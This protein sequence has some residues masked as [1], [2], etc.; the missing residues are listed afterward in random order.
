MKALLIPVEFIK[1]INEAKPYVRIYWL[2]WLSDY[3]DEIFRPD[4]PEYFQSEM[5]GKNVEL[6]LET[7]KEA[8]I[9]GI[10]YFKD[11]FTFSQIKKKDKDISEQEAALVSKVINHLN[12]KCLTT[13][14]PSK[15]NRE[16]ILARAKEGYTISDF[17]RVIDK[18]SSQWM[19]TD[20][21]KYL[22]PIT[23]FQAKKF[24]NYLNEPENLIN[25]GKP[26]TKGTI[27]QLS[28]A[29]NKAK[30]LFT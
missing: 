15:P 16:C 1:A 4:Y 30:Q 17:I 21:Q 27:G 26:K 12:L 2:K 22:R 23:L 9:I 13:Y 5:K 6:S 7:I 10:P 25:D 28:S 11:G 8:Y 14:T 3:T 29:A 19:N 20:Q 24:D 18:K